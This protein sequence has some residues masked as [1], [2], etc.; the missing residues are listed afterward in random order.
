MSGK[1]LVLEIQSKTGFAPPPLR[2]RIF[3]EKKILRFFLFSFLIISFNSIQVFPLMF[4]CSHTH[5]Q[6]HQDLDF[7]RL[8]PIFYS[9]CFNSIFFIYVFCIFFIGQ[10]CQSL[11]CRILTALRPV[12]PGRCSSQ[13]SWAMRQKIVC[14]S[15]R[16]I[17]V[18]EN[19]SLVFWDFLH[20][21]R[22]Q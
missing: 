16:P 19:G 8:F 20:E 4:S 13:R 17:K 14:P 9:I 11:C 10:R 15:V 2:L 3:F 21:V 7:F 12:R 5:H 6:W 22:Q 1:N 18:R